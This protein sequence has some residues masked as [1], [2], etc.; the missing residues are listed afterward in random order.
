M[1]LNELIQAID[2]TK[3]KAKERNYKRNLI[4]NT[5]DEDTKA[6]LKK[7]IL[8]SQAEEAKQ[9]ATDYIKQLADIKTPQYT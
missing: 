4:K 9:K 3:D 2:T 6:R 1:T 8:T 5:E 7:E